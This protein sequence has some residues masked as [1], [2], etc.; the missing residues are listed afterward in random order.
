MTFSG[1]QL[2]AKPIPQWQPS[3]FHAKYKPWLTGTCEVAATG[4]QADGGHEATSEFILRENSVQ[5][6]RLRVLVVE[7]E[8]I[9][10]MDIEM[11]L[12]DLGIEVVGIAMSAAE[13]DALVRKHQPDFLTMDINIKGD[14]DGVTAAQDIW[15]RHGVRSIFISAYSDQITRKRAANCH[16]IAWIEKPIVPADLADAVKK[17]GLKGD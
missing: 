4:S 7:D 3:T 8:A 11:M 15:D 17:A 13:A 12:E 14:Q 10:A 2:V 9:V 5:S 1:A 16:A 6:G